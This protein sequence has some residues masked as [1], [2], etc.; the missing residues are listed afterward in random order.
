MTTGR[1]NQ[2][3]IILTLVIE[4]GISS[5]TRWLTHTCTAA[6]TRI[7]S[8]RSAVPVVAITTRRLPLS[9]PH[10]ITNLG[11]AAIAVSAVSTD[12]PL[13]YPVVTAI[14]EAKQS[15]WFD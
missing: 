4:S 5:H 15:E 8:Y 10:R 1:I 7:T 3:A 6:M 2:V 13:L 14:D 12:T 11:L 9:H